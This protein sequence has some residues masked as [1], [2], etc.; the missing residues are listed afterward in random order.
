MAERTN[1]DLFEDCRTCGSVSEEACLNLCRTGKYAVLE[2][3]V[4]PHPDRSRKP[5]DRRSQEANGDPLM[6]AILAEA[7]RQGM[8]ILDLSEF[9]GV[10][11]SSLSSNAVGATSPRL[12]MLRK[13]LEAIDCDVQIVRRNQ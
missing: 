3:R 13:L 2:L 11:H 6:V 5:N 9:A 4:T 7:K 12:T 10:S 1:W 8:S